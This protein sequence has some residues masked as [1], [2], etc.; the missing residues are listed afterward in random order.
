MWDASDC[1]TVGTGDSF[2]SVKGQI[3]EVNHV[4][5]CSEKQSSFTFTNWADAQLI[6]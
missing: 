5:C 6:N 4:N 3:Y 2:R 1:Q